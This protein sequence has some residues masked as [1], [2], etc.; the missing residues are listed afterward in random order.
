MCDGDVICYP[1]P[2]MFRGPHSLTSSETGSVRR[3][4]GRCDVGQC[5]GGRSECSV[6]RLIFV[7][8]VRKSPFRP[9]E[10]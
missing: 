3:L 1:T 5:Q 4:P 2:K 8:V 10:S 7:R 9:D 6:K